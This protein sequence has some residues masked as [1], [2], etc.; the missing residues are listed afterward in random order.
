MIVLFYTLIHTHIH[1]Q[2]DFYLLRKFP[3]ARIRFKWRQK[4]RNWIWDPNVKKSNE[5]IN[6]KGHLS[7]KPLYIDLILRQKQTISI[8][9]VWK[10]EK[11]RNAHNSVVVF[12][13]HSHCTWELGINYKY[14]EM[15]THYK[16]LKHIQQRLDDNFAL[17]IAQNIKFK[18]AQKVCYK[19]WKWQESKISVIVLF[20]CL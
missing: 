10:T 15:T 2:K 6:K 4:F 19:T 9:H 16:L 1:I 18:S 8:F 14:E 13:N 5:L 12:H 11:E 17:N 3:F 20:L 7:Q